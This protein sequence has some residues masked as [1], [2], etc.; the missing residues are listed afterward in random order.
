MGEMT[1]KQALQIVNSAEKVIECCDFGD[2]YGFAF[3]E[4]GNVGSAYTCVR[5]SNGEVFAFMPYEDFE[6][7]D[8]GIKIPLS[9]L[10]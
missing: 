3:G 6:L 4:S 10:E 7:F 9:E 8:K 5:K 1:A 2:F